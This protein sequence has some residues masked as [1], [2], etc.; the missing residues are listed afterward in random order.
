MV[1][2]SSVVLDQIQPSCDCYRKHTHGY[3]LL[4]PPDLLPAGPTTDWCVRLILFI[5]LFVLWIFQKK[6]IIRPQCF[7]ICKTNMSKL[8]T[9]KLHA[10][11]GSQ[12]FCYLFIFGGQIVGFI[13][14]LYQLDFCC[15]YF[16]VPIWTFVWFFIVCLQLQSL[17][18]SVRKS[19]CVCASHWSIER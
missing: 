13:C 1:N 15:F 18:V 6:L 10:C 12:A 7:I 11:S 19:A 8:T 14:V 5:F 16:F 17:W 3:S 2:C 4:S 9:V